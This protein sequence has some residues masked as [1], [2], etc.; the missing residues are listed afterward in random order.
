M[1]ELV[2]IPTLPLM[3]V[4]VIVLIN[5]VLCSNLKAIRCYESVITARS[6]R[7]AGV[8]LWQNETFKSCN[9]LSKL[10]ILLQ[11]GKS[12][13]SVHVVLESWLIG[14]LRDFAAAY[15]SYRSQRTKFTRDN[16]A[17]TCSFCN[18]SDLLVTCAGNRQMCTGFSTD[19]A[20]A[21][22]LSLWP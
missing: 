9:N 12:S 14:S 7:V 19:T 22:R 2:V 18:H 10:N 11:P 1:S 21:E 5:S 15:R 6:V 3:E 8:F 20:K 13:C 17:F 16:V 4:E